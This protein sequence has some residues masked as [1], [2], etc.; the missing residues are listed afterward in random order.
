MLLP[1]T[2]GQVMEAVLDIIGHVPDLLHPGQ[3][4]LV[5]LSLLMRCKQESLHHLELVP[6]EGMVALEAQLQ[7]NLLRY[8]RFGIAKC[9][10]E[11]RFANTEHRRLH[12]SAVCLSRAES[13]ID[14]CIQMQH[15]LG[16]ERRMTTKD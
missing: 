10:A 2:N 16:M 7:G 13:P 3:Y 1:Q 8:G 11:H 4:H 9:P 5:L 14:V 12:G 6:D 15:E